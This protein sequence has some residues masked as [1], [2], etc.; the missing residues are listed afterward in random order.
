M[1]VLLFV[2]W[3]LMN[4]RVTA[5]LVVFGLLIAAAVSFFAYKVLRYSPANDRR[6]LRNLPLLLLYVLN[7]VREI[8]KASFLVMGV[9]W[10]GEQPDPVIVELNSGFETDLQNVLLANSITL[11]PGTITLFQEKDHFV[12][13][14]LKREYAEGMEDSSFVRLLR[15]VR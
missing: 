5:E 10:R 12:I 11:T 9:A 1:P 8:L 13:H 7:L 2:I 4:G 3:I 15:R 14:C 6:I